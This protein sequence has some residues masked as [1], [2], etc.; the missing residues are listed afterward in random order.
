MGV[1]DAMIAR[2]A[3]QA[4]RRNPI[5]PVTPVCSVAAGFASTDSGKLAKRPSGCK[6]K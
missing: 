2:V 4:H 3:V 1:L 5:A 6:Q